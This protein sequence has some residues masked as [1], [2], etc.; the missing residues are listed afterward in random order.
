VLDA[1][2]RNA[3]VINWTHGNALDLDSD[4]NLLVSF[5][6]LSE[7]TKI[8]THTGAVIWRM[9]GSQNQIT[10]ENVSMPAFVHQHGLRAVG[11]GQVIL[12]DNLGEP[13]ASRAER[14]QVDDAHRTA[15]LTGSYG[16]PAGLI[17]LIGGS[18]QALP[19]G[20]TLVSFGNGGGVEEY[21][22]FGEVAWSI[23]GKPGYIFRATR[24]RSLYQ[25]AVGGLR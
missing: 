4:G 8:D 7:V 3:S 23:G 6:N 10:F 5:R 20:H 24:I 18:T 17:A 16:A 13:L 11:A 1:V 22:A 15:R 2:D 9:G 21:D 14:Y 12:L 25:P 19:N